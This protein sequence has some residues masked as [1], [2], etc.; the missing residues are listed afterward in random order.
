MIAHSRSRFPAVK[1]RSGVSSGGKGVL[2]RI[3][4][5]V[6]FASADVSWVTAGGGE[7]G[8]GG[9]PAPG[10]PSE[11]DPGRGDHPDRLASVLARQPRDDR[12]PVEEAEQPERAQ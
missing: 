12:P 7:T 8:G 9:R 11:G 5:G 4:A 1:K 6:G 2:V 3:S 10:D